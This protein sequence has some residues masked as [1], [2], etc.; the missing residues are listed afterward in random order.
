[1]EAC[2]VPLKRNNE[3]KKIIAFVKFSEEHAVETTI[4]ELEE[5]MQQRLPY[6]MMPAEIISVTVFPFTASHKI[7]KNKLLADYSQ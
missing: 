5:F 2:V 4:K 1:L 3:V 7:D 6:Y